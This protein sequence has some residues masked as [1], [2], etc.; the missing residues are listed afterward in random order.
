MKCKA[1]HGDCAGS[2][3]AWMASLGWEGVWEPGCIQMAAGGTEQP[4]SAISREEPCD[5]AGPKA[6]IERTKIATTK[7]DAV[8]SAHS[9]GAHKWK[10]LG[11]E[12]RNSAP[13]TATH[14]GI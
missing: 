13:G 8:S 7:V 5:P 1:S 10:R 3:C 9:R 14:H 4:S 11:G 12:T 2:T 6:W